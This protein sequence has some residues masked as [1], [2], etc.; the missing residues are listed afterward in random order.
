MTTN[1][2]FLDM[3]LGGGDVPPFRIDAGDGAITG[4]AFSRIYV[5]T[6]CTLTTLTD[7]ADANMLTA[8]SVT[9]DTDEL[10]AGFIFGAGDG[11]TIKTI[12]IQTGTSGVVWGI[13]QSPTT[14]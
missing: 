10:P 5:D 12:T 6:A 1:A 14:V 13:T 7:S 4:K 8:M 3:I 11:K 9:A 2:Q